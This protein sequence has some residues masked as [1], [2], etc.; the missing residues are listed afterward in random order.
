VRREDAERLKKLVG[1]RLAAK[2]RARALT[3]EVLAVSLGVSAQ[4]VGLVERGVENLT[5]ETLARFANAVGCTVRDL[6]DPSEPVDAPRPGR[7][8][9]TAN[10]P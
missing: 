2:R 5:I 3:Q 9:G 10:R 8:R 1:R 7:P 6:F 4:Y